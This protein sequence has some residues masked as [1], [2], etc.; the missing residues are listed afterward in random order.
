MPK[1]STRNPVAPRPPEFTEI[2]P[3]DLFT[4]EEAQTAPPSKVNLARSP[5]GKGRKV[6]PQLR[7]LVF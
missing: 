6:N 7:F 2:N 4:P 1:R 5:N 3:A